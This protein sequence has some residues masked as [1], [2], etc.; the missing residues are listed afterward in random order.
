LVKADPRFLNY[1]GTETVRA[2][3]KLAKSVKETFNFAD[4]KTFSP[5]IFRNLSRTQVDAV[6]G[7]LKLDV[8][9]QPA[10][11]DPGHVHVV[12]SMYRSG[13]ARADDSVLVA[14]FDKETIVNA[15][16]V[17]RTVAAVEEAQGLK[18]RVQAAEAA[19]AAAETRDLTNEIRIKALEEILRDSTVAAEPKMAEFRRKISE[20]VADAE[21]Q[22]LT[23]KKPV[24]RRRKPGS[25]EGEGGNG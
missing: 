17:P 19:L 16:A 8:S 5:E 2:F 7:L 22:R 11:L 9:Y 4:P 20:A 1:A 12:D 6:A 21:A 13:L 18:T 10:Q 23:R 14:E 25:P 15:Y 3:S 24:R